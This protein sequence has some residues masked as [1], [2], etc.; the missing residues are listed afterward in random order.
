MQV[1]KT[2]AESGKLIMNLYHFLV[3]ILGAIL[4]ILFLYTVFPENV[5]WKVGGILLLYLIPPAGKESMVP[6]LVYLFR[7]SYGIWS[8]LLASLLISM[9]DILVSW[10][11]TWNWDLVK[12][13][14]L[15]GAY[16]RKIEKIGEKKWKEHPLIR[17]F[18]YIGLALFVAIPFQGSGGFTA[19]IIGR[20][21]G[22]SQYKV[23]FAVATGALFGCFVIASLTYFTILKFGNWG[24]FTIGGIIIFVLVI[25]IVYKWM[26]GEKK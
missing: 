21:L 7:D 3:P 18:A 12:L 1:P 14:P 8:I 19:T 23:L 17:K 5:F 10:W 13:I 2:S 9:I 6:A 16:V 4:F 22:M 11:T 25:G 26:K 20:L 24:I 15:V